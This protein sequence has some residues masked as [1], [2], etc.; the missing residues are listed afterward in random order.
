ML[1][2]RSTSHHF[3]IVVAAIAA[4]NAARGYTIVR[5]DGTTFEA[6][7]PATFEDGKALFKLPS[8]SKGF[9]AEDLV[10]KAATERA[11][12]T[13]AA[14]LPGGEFKEIPTYKT[15][16][17]P[18]P[19]APPLG[20]IAPGG[21]SKDAFTQDDVPPPTA[22]PKRG[23]RP[24]SPAPPSAPVD[25]TNVVRAMIDAGGDAPAPGLSEIGDME[26][27]DAERRVAVAEQQRMLQEYLQ[28]LSQSN[29]MIA[30]MLSRMPA[31]PGP[32]AGVVPELNRLRRRVAELEKE[33]DALRRL[34]M[35]NGVRP[36]KGEAK[37]RG[38]AHGAGSTGK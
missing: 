34:L 38:E 25:V 20:S 4:W 16:I 3:I 24:A 13:W 6:E 30:D 36:E 2:K 15:T 21:K 17:P 37:A 19:E 1:A 33:N 23:E 14:K 9:M 11:N 10:D 12:A 35:E 29:P 5:T 28:Q 31:T 22:R 8:G 32:S 26:R 27:F 18:R 7:G